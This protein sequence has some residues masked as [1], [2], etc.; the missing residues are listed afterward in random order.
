M[1]YD[2]PLVASWE[3]EAEV[4]RCAAGLSSMEARSRGHRRRCGEELG[5]FGRFAVPTYLST[6]GSK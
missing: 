5:R 4:V 2:R 3:K 1:T 6:R